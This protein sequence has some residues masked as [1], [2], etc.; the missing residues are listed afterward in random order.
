MSVK[1]CTLTCLLHDEPDALLKVAARHREVAWSAQLRTLE[2]LFLDYYRV[3]A[4]QEESD[5]R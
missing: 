2:E 1:G 5:A 3:P 4:D